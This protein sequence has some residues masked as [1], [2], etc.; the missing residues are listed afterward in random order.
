M[1]SYKW[2]LVVAF[3]SFLIVASFKQLP[4]SSNTDTNIKIA[5]FGFA[6]RVHAPKSL[7]TR[8]GTPTYVAPEILLECPYDERVDLWSI[9]GEYC[10]CFYENIC[11]TR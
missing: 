10:C 3:L 7:R 6:K 2:A 8:L 9:G 5:D 1:V 11:M 4:Y